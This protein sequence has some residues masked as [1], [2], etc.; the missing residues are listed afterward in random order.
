MRD[1]LRRKISVAAGLDDPY[2]VL[3]V[4]RGSGVKTIK[5]AYYRRMKE[6][7]PDLNPNSDATEA[8]VQIN[9]AYWSVLQGEDS[10]AYWQFYL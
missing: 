5:R 1:C 9:L 8:A 2:I 6:V 3:N 4:P 7:H 10:L